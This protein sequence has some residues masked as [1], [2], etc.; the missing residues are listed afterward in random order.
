[1]ALRLIFMGTPDF[2]LPTLAA[3]IDAG[4][5]IACVYSQPPRPAGRGQ[6]ERPS[7]VHKFSAARNINVRTPVSLKDPTAQ[8]DFAALGADAAIVAAYGLILPKAILQAPRLGCLNLH[9][10]LLPRWRGAAPIQRAIM[11]GDALSGVCIMQMDEGLDTGAVLARHEIALG[12]QTTAGELHDALASDGAAL[13]AAAL[14]QLDAGEVS[15]APQSPDGVTYA[16]KIGKHEARIDWRL[17]AAEL[18]RLIRAM[19]PFPGAW[20]SYA[21]ERIKVLSA[22]PS[23]QQGEAGKV[24]DGALTVACG[25]GS[26]ALETVQRGGRKPMSAAALL[27][28]FALPAGT[29]LL[30]ETSKS[31]AK[32]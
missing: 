1:M 4:H 5:D 29:D 23:S 6:S 3:L 21:G 32:I 18:D 17:S 13:M 10:S 7:P 11:A 2:A 30:S 12:A 24:L 20:F 31:H 9:G 19:A 16:A 22:R 26:L 27:H 28:G 14:A 15:A 25:D 8:R